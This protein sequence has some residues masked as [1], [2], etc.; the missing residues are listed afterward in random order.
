MTF[1]T[2]IGSKTSTTRRP[3]KPWSSRIGLRLLCM[4]LAFPPRLASER[5]NSGSDQHHNIG[6]D[7]YIMDHLGRD[8]VKD[9]VVSL[10]DCLQGF[11]LTHIV[12]LSF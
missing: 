8:A 1:Q 2:S 10:M 5:A 4:S 12:T 11:S 3:P 6:P 9:E 7:F